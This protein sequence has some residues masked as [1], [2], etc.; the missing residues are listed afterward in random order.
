MG[1]GFGD[2]SATL[3]GEDLISSSG[4][5]GWGSSLGL[6]VGVGLVSLRLVG[7]VVRGLGSDTVL[8]ALGLASVSLG[9]GFFSFASWVCKFMS[10]FRSAAR[11]SINDFHRSSCASSFSD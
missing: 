9:V 6:L 7:G 3:H 5:G 8:L 4:V 1:C 10:I 11:F 2:G